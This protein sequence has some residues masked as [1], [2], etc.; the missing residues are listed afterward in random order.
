MGRTGLRAVFSSVRGLGS[1]GRAGS[2]GMWTTGTIRGMD[3]MGRCQIV[4]RSNSTI[5]REMRLVMGMEMLGKR[6]IR[7]A[8]SMR[9]RGFMAVVA[10]AIR[11]GN[12]LGR[13]PFGQEAPFFCAFLAGFEAA[14]WGF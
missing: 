11:T 3:T 14:R 2:M 7:L 5:S 9:C 10:A 8:E 12:R 4:E 1:T 13:V 6:A